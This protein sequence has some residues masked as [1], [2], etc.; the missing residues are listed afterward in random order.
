MPIQKKAAFLSL[1]VSVFVLVFKAYAY[2]QTKSLAIMSD[3]LESVVNVVTGVLAMVVVRIALMPADDEHPYGHGKVEHFSAAF[4]GGL[5]FFAALAII[6]ESISK[7]IS[8]VPPINLVQ[9]IFYSAIASLINLAVGLFILNIGRKHNSEALKAN[10][11]H[12]LSDVITTVGIIIGLGLVLITGL[13]ILDPI[14]GALVGVW[15]SYEAFKIIR[16]NFGALLD[17][18]DPEL[19]KRI[20]AAIKKNKKPEIIDVHN[21]RMIRSGSFHHIDAHIVVPEFMSLTDVEILTHEFERKVVKEYAFDGEFAFHLDPCKKHYCSICEVDYCKIR[22]RPFVEA[23]PL[24][25]KG[26]ISNPRHTD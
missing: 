7:M 19:I 8:P 5:I 26:L 14:I 17:R 16:E 22:K 23:R 3:A 25:E 18:K 15:L 9:G 1:F 13:G 24:T 21:L 6:Y 10:G 2:Y 20:L 12:L 11:K 4:E